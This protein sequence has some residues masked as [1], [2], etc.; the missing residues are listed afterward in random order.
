MGHQQQS[1]W[2]L[3]GT[4]HALHIQQTTCSGTTL[5]IL[6]ARI[7]HLSSD[8]S[9][10]TWLVLCVPAPT[11]HRVT[12]HTRAPRPAPSPHPLWTHSG[13]PSHTPTKFTLC[14]P[15]VLPAARISTL[16]P[17]LAALLCVY[18]ASSS[19][20]PPS[21][22]SLSPFPPLAPPHHAASL[23]YLRPFHVAPRQCDTRWG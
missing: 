9:F 16:T 2:W 3:L 11:T 18:P 7:R 8:F 5:C 22:L 17:P 19:P 15:R 6:L 1:V 20:P 23:C 14:T 4:K 12:N 10:K 13:P 21:F